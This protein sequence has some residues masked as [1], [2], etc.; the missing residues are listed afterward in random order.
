[1]RKKGISA[2]NER[3]A[4]RSGRT[5]V[6]ETLAGSGEKGN[7]AENGVKTAGKKKTFCGKKQSSE[8]AGKF[9]AFMVRRRKKESLQKKV[10]RLDRRIKAV[11][12]VLNALVRFINA[13]DQKTIYRH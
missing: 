9:A 12:A 1:M 6:R 13:M 7:K 3:K 11:L 5:R 10:K 4:R 8:K 2:G